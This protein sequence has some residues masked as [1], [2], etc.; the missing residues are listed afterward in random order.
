MV[1]YQDRLPHAAL[2]PFIHYYG[3]LR[4]D[5]LEHGFQECVIPSLS[6]GIV[7]WRYHDEPLYVDN[8]T[9]QA[10]LPD[11][12]LLGQGSSRHHWTHY[13][14][15]DSFAI[16]FRPGQMRK[17]FHQPWDETLN[18]LVRIEESEDRGLQELYRQIMDTDDFDAW[19]RYADA[20]FLRRYRYVDTLTDKVDFALDCIHA[21]PD[22]NVSDLAA[23]L[24]CTER[25]VH[26]LFRHKLGITPKD[27]QKL[28][29][30]LV[31]ISR[32]YRGQY[33][34][35]SDLAYDLGFSDQAHFSRSFRSFLDKTPREF[36]REQAATANLKLS[37][38]EGNIS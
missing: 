32:M 31:A 21:H 27:Y 25:H 26:R 5:R 15:L 18:G 8:G 36:I 4:F 37:G 17:A 1:H 11:G 19:C 23:A 10:P 28:H 20:F 9:F 33:E 3:C 38:R 13:G 14:G 22:W 12:F 35:L 2:R 24:D 34:K 16:I 29:R 7:F 30:L 6:K